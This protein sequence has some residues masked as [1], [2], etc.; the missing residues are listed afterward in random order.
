M[1]PVGFSSGARLPFSSW[2]YGE[3]LAPGM[4]N[5]KKQTQFFGFG[6]SL[7]AI[8]LCPLH[9]PT[10]TLNSTPLHSTPLHTSIIQTGVQ[11]PPSRAPST[12]T[13]TQQ[14]SKLHLASSK[15]YLCRDEVTRSVTPK[16]YILP[17]VALPAFV[18]TQ[19]SH[20]LL[21]HSTCLT[22]HLTSH[23]TTGLSTN[24]WYP[25]PCIFQAI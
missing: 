24:S 25:P 12:E 15:V 14:G 5:R 8:P 21:L 4:L 18:A 3:A 11:V 1:G 7:A 6:P 17:Y 10:S 13:T 2:V 20:A 9:Q 19:L 23:V 16:A 22:M